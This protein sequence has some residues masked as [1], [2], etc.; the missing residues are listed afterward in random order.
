MENNRNQS[1]KQFHKSIHLWGRIT[2]LVALLCTLTIPLYLTFV[3]GYLPNSA[4]I[5]SG[6]IS[7]AGFVGIIWFIEPISYFPTL[8]PAGTYMSFLSGNIGNMRLPVIAATQDALELTPGSNEAE[9]AGIFALISST[10]TNL[11]VLGIVLVAGQVIIT[12]MPEAIISS[13]NFALP[14]ILG[15]MMIMMGSKIKVPNLV[16]LVATAIAIMI[17]IRFAPNFLPANI[18]TPISVADTG[19]VAIF[20]ILYSV[21]AAK[22]N[23]AKESSKE[24]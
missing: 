14:G 15:A 23:H 19:I 4:D 22:K 3:L 6:M 17:F 13:F 24:A 8:G 1:T 7:I 21:I 18:A 5:I 12:V 16:V 11:V 10:F 9:V 20:G 2:I